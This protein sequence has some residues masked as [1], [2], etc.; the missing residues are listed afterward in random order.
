MSVVEVWGRIQGSDATLTSQEGNI[1]NFR[2][3]SWATNPVIAEFWAEDDAGNIG[4]R[5]A[6][7]TIDQ[8]T[9]KCIHWMH[10]DGICLMK[11]VVRG[12][13][14]TNVRS[15]ITMVKHV[16]PQMEG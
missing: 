11:K 7:L 8:G 10:T 2:V 3:P 16:C 6:V 4:Y 1:W 5:S 13:A 14:V 15:E 12:I 9:V